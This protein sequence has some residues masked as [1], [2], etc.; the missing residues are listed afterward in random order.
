MQ[1]EEDDPRSATEAPSTN[2][3][4]GAETETSNHGGEGG[5]IP[6]FWC[7]CH[8]SPTRLSLSRLRRRMPS[9]ARVTNPRPCLRSRRLPCAL[10]CARDRET[11]TPEESTGT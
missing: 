5:V 9:K 11:D 2:R 8:R 4:D 6:R 7:I 10:V 3:Q 1:T